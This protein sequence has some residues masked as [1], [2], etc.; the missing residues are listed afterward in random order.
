M[1]PCNLWGTQ[2]GMLPS[3]SKLVTASPTP[4]TWCAAFGGHENLHE[5]AELDQETALR[6]FGGFTVSYLTW[7]DYEQTLDLSNQQQQN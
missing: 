2:G 7:K 1:P 6:V 5:H 3:I 4:L